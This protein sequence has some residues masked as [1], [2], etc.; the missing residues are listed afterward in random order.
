ME[1]RFYEEYTRIQD[2]HWWFAGRRRIIGSV[3][4][5]RLP[6]SGDGG[7]RIL[8]VGCG[9]GTNLTELS[10]FGRVEGVDTESAAVEFCRSRGWSVGLSA[11]VGLPFDD[12]SFE[13]VTLLDVI[14]HVDEDRA[15]LAEARRVLAPNGIVL[16]T[17]P[18]YNWMWGRQDEIAHHKRRYT[19][20]RLARALTG[21]GLEPLQLSYFN[22]L[23]FPPIAVIRLLRRLRPQAAE[24]IS[25]FEVNPSGSLN[26]PLARIF[27]FEGWLL[28]R[29]RLPFGVSLIAIAA[30]RPGS[31]R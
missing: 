6:P 14:E 16:I 3:L 7:V 22:T 21:A 25:D 9:T 30:D 26:G 2:E 10:R 13:V 5:R 11:G 24:T 28:N 4:S 29:V 17:V 20:G 27:G 18:A 1:E 15:L 12:G 19:R 31:R 8:D 23:L